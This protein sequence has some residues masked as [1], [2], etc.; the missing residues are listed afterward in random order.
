MVDERREKRERAKEG[1]NEKYSD[2]CGSERPSRRIQNPLPRRATT[3]LPI[4]RRF[5][6]VSLLAESNRMGGSCGGGVGA[7]RCTGGQRLREERQTEE[8]GVCACSLS[9]HERRIQARRDCRFRSS[10]Q[11]R[12]S[13]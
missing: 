1:S 9:L 2:V 10:S 4:R 3:L 12:N 6:A 13:G 7:F 11:M 8:G 5:E